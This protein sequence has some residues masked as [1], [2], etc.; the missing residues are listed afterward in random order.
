MNRRTKNPSAQLAVYLEAARS[1]A[2]GQVIKSSDLDRIVRERLTAA[3]YLS[4]VM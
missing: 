2:K 3:G 1:K 4:R